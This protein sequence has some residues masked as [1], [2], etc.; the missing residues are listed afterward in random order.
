VQDQLASIAMHRV[1]RPAAKDRPKP[2]LRFGEMRD[3]HPLGRLLIFDGGRFASSYRVRDRQ[4]MVVNRHVGKENL[5]I[6]VLENDRNKEGLFLPRGYVVQYWEEG[7]GRLLRTETIEDR[8]ERVGSWDLPTRH[9]VTT[10]AESGLSART[11]TL[12]KHELSR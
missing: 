10:A 8:W 5:T 2:V 7:T 6:C 12:S 9:S 3:K 1:A 4:L 11:F